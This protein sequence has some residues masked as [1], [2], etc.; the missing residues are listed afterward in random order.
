[1]LAEL[2]GRASQSHV[3]WHAFGWR[4]HTLSKA[5]GALASDCMFWLTQIFADVDV[6]LASGQSCKASRSNSR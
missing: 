4:R 1:M 6:Q 2:V 5:I 3:D